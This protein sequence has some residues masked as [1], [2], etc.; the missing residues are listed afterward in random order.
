MTLAKNMLLFLIFIPL[1]TGNY[2]V[3]NISNN[4]SSANFTRIFE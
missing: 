1:F 2:E 4:Y 3:R